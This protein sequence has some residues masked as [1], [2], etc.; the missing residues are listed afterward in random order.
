MATG[1]VKWFDEEKGLGSISPDGGGEDLF[2]HHSEILSGNDRF[3]HEG[4][5]V[6]FET[7]KDLKGSN[8]IHVTRCE[9]PISTT[10]K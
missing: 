4:E 8:A 2:V 3:L 9:T 6:R 1:T 7:F 10:A 5:R